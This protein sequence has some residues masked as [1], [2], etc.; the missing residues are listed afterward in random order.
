[1]EWLRALDEA[2]VWRAASTLMLLWL[3]VFFGRTLL[4]G[5]VPLIE[6]IARVSEPDMAPALCRYTRRLTAVWCVY[7]VVAAALAM[8]PGQAFVRTGVLV[9]AGTAVLFVGEH[10]LRSRIFPGHAFPGLLQQLRDTWRVWHP[11]KAD[12]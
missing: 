3:A 9:W 12:S 4:P 8:L 11:R 10:W 7:F 1:M 6:R 2:V 5:R